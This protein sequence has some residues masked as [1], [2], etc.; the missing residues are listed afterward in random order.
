VVEGRGQVD[1]V[2]S[3]RP[4]LTRRIVHARAETIPHPH[5]RCAAGRLMVAI[6]MF[7]VVLAAIG[8]F[9]VAGLYG[10]RSV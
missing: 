9:A 4:G 3:D 7:L 5:R 10:R 2:E 8:V 1:A 6:P